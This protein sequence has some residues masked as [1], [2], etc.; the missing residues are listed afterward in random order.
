MS[1]D[2]AIIGKV[3]LARERHSQELAKEKII[4]DIVTSPS[5]H[6]V[7]VLARSAN[8]GLSLKVSQ[9]QVG[10]LTAAFGRPVYRYQE[11]SLKNSRG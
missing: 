10:H 8:K 2:S 1:W 5:Q 4:F 6:E 11:P 9:I 3:W 7:L